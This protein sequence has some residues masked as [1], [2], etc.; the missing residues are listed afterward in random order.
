MHAGMQTNAWGTVM[1]TE[2][3]Q[4]ANTHN[5]SQLTSHAH[6][7]HIPPSTDTPP[8]DPTHYTRACDVSSKLHPQMNMPMVILTHPFTQIHAIVRFMLDRYEHTPPPTNT[9]ALMTPPL[10]PLQLT[11]I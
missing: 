9:P 1:P 10:P 7:Q 11:L 2:T 4:H 5:C 8:I 3:A 6:S